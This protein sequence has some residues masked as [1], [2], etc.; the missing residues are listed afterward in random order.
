MVYLQALEWPAMAMLA[1]W[2]VFAQTKRK[3]LIGFCVFLLSNVLW[4]LLQF[5]L[6]ALDIRGVTKN[7]PKHE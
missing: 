5:A 3:R 7:E 6:A 2:L 1:A 4:I